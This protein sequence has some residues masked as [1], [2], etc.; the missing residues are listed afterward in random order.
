MISQSPIEDFLS[1]SKI[2]VVGVSRGGKKFGNVV[3]RDLRSKG[4]KVYPVNPSAEIVEGV[5]CYPSLN[6]LPESV[7]GAVLVVPPSITNKVVQ[8]A[9]EA[10]IDRIWMQP[11]AESAQAIQFCEQNDMRV[12]FGECIMMIAQPMGV[13]NRMHR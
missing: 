12:V 4:Y 13:A 7:D 6:D 9:H 2:A 11:G 1:Q 3:F 8:N 5:T 10:G